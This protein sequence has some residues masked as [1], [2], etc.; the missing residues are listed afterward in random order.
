MALL[1][2]PAFCMSL[3]NYLLAHSMYDEGWVNNAVFNFSFAA[4][5]H[6]G[7]F[8]NLE[9]LVFLKE[10][11]LKMRIAGKWCN[12]PSRVGFGKK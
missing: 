12:V 10:D 4:W 8:S 7:H 6:S 9:N 5:D 11:Q 2:E 3:W 1:S